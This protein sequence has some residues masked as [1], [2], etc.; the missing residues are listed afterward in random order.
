[1]NGGDAIAER[2]TVWCSLSLTVSPPFWLSS[3]LTTYDGLSTVSCLI[4]CCPILCYDY[5][6][7]ACVGCIVVFWLHA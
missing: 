6:S 1:M 3:F 2:Y 4:S 7:A 5:F